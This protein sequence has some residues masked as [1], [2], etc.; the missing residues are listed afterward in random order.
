[1]RTPCDGKVRYEREPVAPT[2]LLRELVVHPCCDN[3]CVTT[4]LGLPA[5][6]EHICSCVKLR[7]NFAG[8]CAPVETV[9]DL[10]ESQRQANFLEIVKANRAPY[11][12]Y[13]PSPSDSQAVAAEK[14]N[15]CRAD[16]L[17]HFNEYGKRVGDKSWSW[18]A[19]YVIRL[20]NRPSTF[21]CKRAWCAITGTTIRGAE[22]V[23][24][25]IRQGTVAEHLVAEGDELKD[26]NIKDAF[27]HF[28][29][30]IDTYHSYI[31]SFCVLSKIPQSGAPIL[32][33]AWLADYF[34]LVGESQPGVMAIHYDPISKREIYD[35]YIAD[36]SVIGLGHDM[37]SYPQF[38]GLMRDVFPYCTPRE[39]KQVAG[40]CHICESMRQAMK[41]FVLR[42]DRL[43]I[44]RFR[45]FHRN[46]TMG[47]KVKYYGR[48]NEAISSDGLCWSF[49]FD[50]FSKDKTR[51]PILANTA[52]LSDE[53]DMNV[54]GCI[55][56]N[57]KRTQMYVSGPSVRSNSAF[58]IH[59]VHAEIRRCID[60]GERLPDKI[61]LEIDGAADNTA[62]AV[63]G[64]MQHLVSA[65]LCS[66]LEVLWLVVY[67][68]SRSP[69][70]RSPFLAV[71]DPYG[72]LL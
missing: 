12:R 42:S 5:G 38:C 28:G 62:Y 36:E 70:N 41:T 52:S 59:C 35:T 54:M 32:A 46:R 27:Y 67:L 26:V 53:F 48:I 31:Q 1:M 69:Y 13:R 10:T 20:P 8:F 72:V 61:Y 11:D 9:G 50:A 15:Q 33:C 55:F 56:H 49:I 7:P 43:I 68:F 64:A 24:K 45:L 58:M 4:I 22:Y 66:I 21:V 2:D 17:R 40:K 18:D 37:V 30:E 65:G 6:R 39:Y 57:G 71:L 44:K 51:L 60:A 19:A 29:L 16:L 47:E 14:K 3:G 23:Q 63:M 25:L 34:D